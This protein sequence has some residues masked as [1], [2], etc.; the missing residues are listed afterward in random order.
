MN[1]AVLALALLARHGD[2][3]A[4]GTPAPR[5]EARGHDGRAFGEDF[6]GRITIVDFFAT[7][8]PHCRQSLAGHD[9]LMRAFGDRVRLLVIDVE[10]DPALV[11][12]FFGRRQLPAG[13]ELLLD[14]AGF[15]S[16]AWRVTGFPTLYVVDRA[17]VLRW[18]TSGYDDSDITHLSKLIPKLEKE[19]PGARVARK[20]G[21]GGDAAEAA[22]D[23]AHARALGVEVLR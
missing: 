8:C 13:A 17:G 4:E 21:R 3:L 19:R 23:D 9:R 10:E 22:A 6:E 16:R 5:I 11:R 1:A 15:T 20:R 7:W 14:P 12:A 2:Y 18:A